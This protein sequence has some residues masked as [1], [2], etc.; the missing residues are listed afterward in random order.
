MEKIAIIGLSSL[1]PGAESPEQYWQNLIAK[2]DFKSLAT[3]E[4]MGVDPQ[5]FY[6]TEKGK[7][8]KYYCLK[9]GYIRN[10]QLDTSEF[11]MAPE[12]LK[13]LDEIYQWSLY[14]SKQALKDSGYLGN[15][16]VL[17]KCGVILG[18]LSF[19]TRFSH[20]FFAPI[21]QKFLDSALQQLLKEESFQLKK[22][23]SDVS[24]LNGMLAGYPAAVIAQA[25]S[26]SGINLSLD[27][28]CATSLYAVKLACHY[29]LSGKADL[30][31][32]GAVS[33]A[34]PFFINM[35][36]SIFHAYP[37][38][39]ISR[40]FDKSSGGLVAGEGAGMVVLKRYSD[41]LRD[42]DRIYATICGVGLS[43]DGKGKFVLSP[44]PKGQILAF[45][46]AYTEAG[47][48][49]NSIDY[50]ECHATGTP[51][52]D[53]TELNSMETFFGQSQT[54]P[55]I[56]SVK[57][58]FGHLLTAAGIA[59]LIKV[60]LSMGEEVI[61]ATIDV[62]DPL[63]S[64]KGAIAAEQMVTSPTPWPQKQPTKRA[65]I[66]AF[67]FGGT[68]A[69]LILE[70]SEATAGE[71]EDSQSPIPNPQLNTQHST[72]NTQ[73][74][75]AIVGMDAF[76]GSCK[77]LDAFERTIY[78]GTQHFIP[79]PPQRWQGIE[80]QPQLLKEYGLAN[81]EAP[82]G[83][84][85]QDFELDFLNFKI[86]PRD[87]DQ[88]IPQQLLMLKV[89]DNAIKDAKL[90]QGGNVAV[91]VAMGT[92][93]SLHQYRGRCDLS[94]Q[95]KESLEQANISLS[96]EKLAE[97][98]AITKDSLHPP[99][100]VN[101]Y[102]S[103]IGN[104]MA[105]RISAQWDFTGPSFTISAE[106]NS[107]FKALEVAQLLL[108]NEEVD[109]VVVGAVDLSGGLENVLFRQQLAPINQGIPTLS[110]D[111]NA[112]GWMVGEGAGA[113][114]LKRHET[115]KQEQD[116][117]YAVIDAISLIQDNANHQSTSDR[118]LT[119]ACQQ[120]FDLAGI[121]PTDIG[122]LEVFGSGVASEDEAEIK[123]LLSAYQTSQA[124]LGCCLGSVKANIGHTYTASG[125]ASLIKTVLC[126]Y[127]RYIPATPQWSRPK[128]PQM[129][130]GSPFYVTTESRTW[131]L[132][133]EAS[134]RVAAINGLGIDGTYSHIILS[135]ELSQKE[136]PSKYLEQTPFYLFPL[137]ANHQSALLERLHSL[138]N[139]IETGDDLS[140]AATQTFTAFGKSPQATYTLAI[141]G[142][143]KQEIL[144]EIHLAIAGIKKSFETGGEWKTPLGSYFTPKPLGNEGKVAFVYPGMASSGLGLG[145]DI[146]QLF[147]KVYDS[148]SALTP[149]PGQVMHEKLH[150]PKSLEKLS[151]QAQA[152]KQ[153]EFLGD[154]VAMC[155]T[156]I[157]LAV[158]YSLILRQYFQVQP[159][160][161][162]GYSLGEASSMLFALDIWRDDGKLSEALVSSP[163]FRTDLC[164]PCL[165]GR[166]FWGLSESDRSEKFWISYV[167]KAPVST[168]KEVLK[169]E[170]RV[171]LSFIN[172]PEEVVIGGDPQACLRVIATLKC[173][174][175]PINFD[176]VLHCEPT[177]TEYEGLVELHTIPIQNVPDIQF[178]SGVNYAPIK[179][180]TNSLAHNA[181][182]ICCI[183]VD[184]PRIIHRVYEDGVRIFI[185]VGAGNNC[186]R[187]IS[188]TLKQ[189]EHIAISI[190]TKGVDDHTGVVRV[191]AKLV[192]HGVSVDLSPLY[193][194]VPEKSIQRQSIVKKVTLGGSRIYSKILTA[195]NCESF[196]KEITRGNKA[197]AMTIAKEPQQTTNHQ[198][199]MM[200]IFQLQ[201][202]VAEQLL[203]QNI[204]AQS[205]GQIAPTTSDPQRN[206]YTKPS[207][208][209]WDEADLLEF[210]EGKISR[211]FGKDYEI[212]DSYSRRV[213][214]PVPPYL[215][216][217]RVT[218]LDGEINSFKPS[219][220]TTEYDIPQNAWYAV[221][222]QAPWAISV[223]SGQCDLLLIS[224]LGIDFENK[225]DLVY[226]LLDCTLTFLDDLPKEGQ[227]LRYDIRIN[228]FVR[229]GDNLLFFFSYECFVGDKMILK[230]D[231]G[232][233]GF[234][235]DEQ[236]ENG[237]GI[238]VSDKELEARSKIP[239]QKFEPL[240]ICQKSSLDESDMLSLTEGNIAACLGDHYWQDGLNP[241]L[242]LP[243]KAML[244]IDRITSV[245]PTGG[246]WGL[247][248]IIGEKFLDPDH[249]YFPCHFKD[250]Q[251]MAGSLMA[252]GCGQLLQFYL[253]Y[254]GLQTYT[255]DAR[256]QP[257]PGL[258]QVVR[259]RGQVT[260]ISG[261]LIYR[262]EITEIGIT[263]KPYAKCNV[264]VI[265][266]GK[267]VVHF[268]DLG[269]QL[270]EKNPNHSI[271][272]EQAI[273]NS[274]QKA[275]LPRKPA[276]LNEDQVN[277]FCLGS[278]AK[279]FGPEFE[280]YDNGGV[281][282]SRMPNTHL[283][284]VHR[285]LE[286]NGKRHE[287][288]KHSSI[289]TE[290]DVPTEPWYYR[291]NSSPTIPYSILMEI[292]LQPCGFL[293][294]YLGTTLLYPNQ[295]L[296]FRNL[297]G[298]GRLLKDIDIRGKTITNTARLLSSSNIQGVIIQS[299][300]FQMV[301]DGE[302][303]YEGTAAFG[304][305]SPQSL[306]NQVG[307]DRGKDV[308]PW[309]E[310]ENTTGLA[311]A[312]ID[313]R[314][315]ES[316][317]KFYR[318]NQARPHYRLAQYQLDLLNE[319]R[320]IQGGGN[321]QQGYI[322]ARKEVKPNDWYFKCHFYLDPVMPGSLGIEGI[323]QAMQ[324][325]ALQNDLGK[326]FKSPR[327][328][329]AIDHLIVWKYRGQIPHGHTEM[330]L[331]VHISKVDI[332]PN[333]VT[334][335]GD[336]SLW[337][338]NLRIYEVKDIALCLVESD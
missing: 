153:A 24:L 192:S 255:V 204:S 94:W 72:L 128:L 138:Q 271:S 219:S 289:V 43:N 109:A 99:A 47:I 212:I 186:S 198:N 44:N 48:H 149:Y 27:A 312:K 207:N 116:R 66:N 88:L 113:V 283:N 110:F 33:C 67:G 278:V 201:I 213:R 304:H 126:L 23:P 253:L 6:S 290:Y 268:Q 49:P 63:R 136:R 232:C 326:Q 38:D 240:L 87:E 19:P 79:L 333:K 101:R 53:I 104:V 248:L 227:T 9:G 250:D 135:E 184:F 317:A 189:Q 89:A 272:V 286:V 35:G 270:S 107:V 296:Y 323:L 10:F 224:Y 243:P 284:L 306:A 57:S 256:F 78:E 322:Y 132:E 37:E 328:V 175:F 277:E 96:P 77:S 305:F 166:R 315:P 17:E 190:N 31:L 203:N 71:G 155:Q 188:E 237:K 102:T 311:K 257:I 142:S 42:G 156:G 137:T 251:V 215:L 90:A 75:L 279:C 16:S 68:N 180:N 170:E 274:Q 230:M 59:G 127:H 115:A 285:V 8:D 310:T 11:Q 55:L 32:A 91:I 97:L 287:L 241:S 60:I 61:P 267:I 73:H 26:L 172:T 133:P 217:S 148:F 165:A 337:K 182:K 160:V 147:P 259:C 179:L 309:Y 108:S 329:Q 231:G 58:N 218:K 130:Q 158:L 221:D 168:V 199:Q 263:P 154:G 252:E 325:Y 129:W 332:T 211:V 5:K 112:N 119:Q 265:L 51:V 242:R 56:G 238:I 254:L 2:K 303:F 293:S 223:E 233:A 229:S 65:A 206:S 64:E 177:N 100:Q 93:L 98:E 114:I 34:D 314:S 7:L 264:E 302:P 3:A 164:G 181:A 334:L 84:Y 200:K 308:P 134:K 291:Q 276:L 220:I 236:L 321:Y 187:W 46:R 162:F 282:A 20:R 36:F 124:S 210:A 214:L 205:N 261:K 81:G 260:P 208:I 297:D 167:L 123:G 45:E 18:N 234:F 95:I 185:E 171:Y 120:A 324:V 335:I 273:N 41:A 269:L 145:R 131:F 300:D 294:A 163:L 141:V 262:M 226:R 82:L 74:S 159:Q 225:G 318:L 22:T 249:W 244:M 106:E 197:K 146:F 176:S 327:F 239:K 235:S 139:L 194:Q 111:E 292:A 13:N 85:I 121:H 144:R 15:Q 39:G 247:G 140:V 50:I 266:N 1:F 29:L 150:Y 183:T 40:P 161:A 288:T 320:I 143:H 4:Q 169:Q 52:G 21:Y 258:P 222:G 299:F 28:A 216:V 62:I 54:V 191:L 196:R 245:E 125:M 319:V 25:L 298:Q 83:A 80:E 117:I 69:H 178:Y 281:K 70:S 30:M 228:S 152:E 301:C 331:E 246:A 313:L 92:E 122:Y 118:I 338:P 173:K 295:D 193:S 86:P 174:Y 307:L 316:R 280:I 330:Y 105:S 103:F 151:S 209:V 336:A 195:E 12:F 202:A 14:V 157:S 76:F 275:G